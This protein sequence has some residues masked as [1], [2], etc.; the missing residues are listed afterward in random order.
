MSTLHSDILNQLLL[1][2]IDLEMR[3]SIKHLE[4][5]IDW[6][7]KDL[8]WTE[9]WQSIKN[10]YIYDEDIYEGRQS[11][12]LDKFLSEAKKAMAEQCEVS[13]EELPQYISR[14]DRCI[15]IADITLRHVFFCSNESTGAL[16]KLDAWEAL[17]ALTLFLECG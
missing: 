13:K 1:G 17:H 2:R 7:L 16:N 11:Y 6:V 15:R 10:K 3:N 4:K 14:L 9:C 12:H 8:S 5:I